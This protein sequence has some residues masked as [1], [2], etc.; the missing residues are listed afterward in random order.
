MRFFDIFLAA[1]CCYY[2]SGFVTYIGKDLLHSVKGPVLL[3][4][5]LSNVVIAEMARAIGVAKRS[6][7]GAKTPTIFARISALAPLLSV[8][9]S[10]Q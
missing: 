1:V 3:A 10:A 5:I 7:A 2:A 9:A 4:T 8:T 6:G